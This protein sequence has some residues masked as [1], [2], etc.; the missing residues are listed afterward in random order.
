[1]PPFQLKTT[2]T[3][4]IDG[5]FLP[6]FVA[7]DHLHSADCI[8]ALLYQALIVPGK[9]KTLGIAPVFIKRDEHS[10]PPGAHTPW[11]KPGTAGR[12]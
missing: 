8:E 1:L 3:A 11:R 2:G 4:R 7:G 10:H 9:E 5:I 6:D 12:L